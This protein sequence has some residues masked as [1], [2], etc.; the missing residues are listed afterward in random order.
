GKVAH[1]AT[2]P[3]SL[4]AIAFPKLPPKVPRSMSFLPS[5]KKGCCSW[6]PVNRDPPTTWPRLFRS[7]AKVQVPPKLPRSFIVP[8][9]QR[10]A[11]AVRDPSPSWAHN[12]LGSVLV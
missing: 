12:S 9:S 6:S 8:L 11:P 10:N 4:R 5:H 1:P 2:S 3:E 7:E